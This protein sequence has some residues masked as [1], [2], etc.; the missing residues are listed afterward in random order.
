MGIVILNGSAWRGREGGDGVGSGIYPLPRT[1]LAVK[2]S[3]VYKID[4]RL[5]LA[6][7]SGAYVLH[8]V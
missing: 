4:I 6:S 7:G 1:Y 5:R 3:E 2:D 8:M